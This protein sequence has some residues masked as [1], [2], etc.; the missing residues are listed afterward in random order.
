M[1][2]QITEGMAAIVIKQMN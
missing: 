1:L 2:W